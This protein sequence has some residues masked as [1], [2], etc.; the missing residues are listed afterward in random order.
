MVEKKYLE[1]SKE[2]KEINLKLK[3]IIEGSEVK[4]FEDERVEQILEYLEEE[5]REGLEEIDHMT[6]EIKEGKLYLNS[7]GRYNLDT[8]PNFYFTCGSLIEV[9]I[10]NKWQCGRIE[11][12]NGEYYFCNYDGEDIKLV[13]GIMARIRVDRV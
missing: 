13:E 10:G 4:T 6:K 5:I 8:M 7:Q 2:L 12:D 1:I 3:G 9:K 11:H